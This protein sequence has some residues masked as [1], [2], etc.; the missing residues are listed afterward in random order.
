M[1]ATVPRQDGKHETR[2]RYAVL[3]Q[4]E[5]RLEPPMFVLSF[6]WAVLLVVE[7]T[8]GLRPWL[9]TA[10][11]AIWVLFVCEFGLRF[12]IAPN[13][14]QF[15]RKNWLSVFA[16]AIPALRVFRIARIVR[17]LRYGQAIRGITLARVL[18]AFNRG[19]LTL[20]RKARLFGAAYVFGLTAL[21]IVLGTAGTY[22]FEHDE[23]SGIQSWGDS[24]WFTAMLVTTIGCE[25]W[26]KSSEARVLAFLISLYSFGVLGYV[27]ATIARLLI[28]TDQQVAAAA[29]DRRAIDA[30]R[31]EIATLSRRLSDATNG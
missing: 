1:I 11:T 5:L 18:T 28:G 22:A 27:T 8:W 4:L 2:E 16:L 20:K 14:G 23:A 7:L 17:L 13:R 10:V 9:Q 31:A 21:V 3:K 19:L 30:L 26:P 6:L 25:Y 12:V 15:L 24:L 29:A